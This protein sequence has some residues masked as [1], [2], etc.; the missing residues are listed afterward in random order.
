MAEPFDIR[1]DTEAFAAMYWFS[2]DL[3]YQDE[4]YPFTICTGEDNSFIEL[5]ENF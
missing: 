5:I 3:Q 1:I 4:E 2:G